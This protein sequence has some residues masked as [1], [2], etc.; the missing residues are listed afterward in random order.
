[1]NSM[2]RCLRAT[3]STQTQEQQQARVMQLC[4]KEMLSRACW[5]GQMQKQVQ[6]NPKRTGLLR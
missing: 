6:T 2:F 4:M 5:Q 1:M 3:R